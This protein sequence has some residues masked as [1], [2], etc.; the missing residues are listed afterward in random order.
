MNGSPRTPLRR[1]LLLICVLTVM[2]GLALIGTVPAFA[3]EGTPPQP[4]A[5]SPAGPNGETIANLFNIVL[6]MAISGGTAGLAGGVEL[7]GVAF[8][9]YQ[10]ISPGFGYD[11]IAVSLLANNNPIG[12]IFSGILFGALRS[13][14]E[15]A[16]I[17]AKIP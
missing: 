2:T 17:T 3:Q 6:V 12:I 5:L 14:S 1:A 4:S 9:L 10:Q 13:G 15:M 16:Q 11:G 8:R 7:A